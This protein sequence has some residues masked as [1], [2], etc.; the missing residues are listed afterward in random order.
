MGH[1]IHERDLTAI[2]FGELQVGGQIF[3]D[4]IRECDFTLL[5]HVSEQEGGEYF[6]DR[7][8]LKDDVAIE[9]TR[10]ALFEMTVGDD[11]PALGSGHT[12]DD[13]DTIFLPSEGVDTIREDL[14]NI[15]IRWEFE[16]V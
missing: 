6:A 5:D 13:A 9:S 11:S 10:V 2:P 3:R 12:D 8:N 4:R 1:Q 7:A 15:G 14:S 16:W